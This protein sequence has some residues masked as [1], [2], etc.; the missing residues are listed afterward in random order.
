MIDFGNYRII[1]S[2][3]ISAFKWQSLLT[4][5]K[6]FVSYSVCYSFKAPP[7]DQ[8][9]QTDWP[10]PVVCT[11]LKVVLDQVKKFSAR[12]TSDVVNLK[13]CNSAQRSVFHWMI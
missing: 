13:T 2:P 11:H 7:G 3:M 4:I 9:C 10:P 6:G 12:Q 8:M 1:I 5:A